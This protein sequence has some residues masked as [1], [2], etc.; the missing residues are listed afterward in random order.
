MLPRVTSIN[1]ESTILKSPQTSSGIPYRSIELPGEEKRSVN[2]SHVFLSSR[3][4][5]LMRSRIR[6]ALWSR[7]YMWADIYLLDH[8]VDKFGK[9]ILG[10]IYFK[11][12]VLAVLI[13]T[14]LIILEVFPLGHWVCAHPVIFSF[15]QWEAVREHTH[16]QSPLLLNRMCM[17]GTHFYPPDHLEFL[18]QRIWC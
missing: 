17:N 8:K 1:A 14:C 12:T 7:R 2:K 16:R 18:H 15:I 13:V 3:D 5:H 10:N 11:R 9:H 4:F 6:R